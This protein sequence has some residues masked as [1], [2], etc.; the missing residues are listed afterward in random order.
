[1]NFKVHDDGLLILD[2]DRDERGLTWYIL[3]LSSFMENGKIYHVVTAHFT[4]TKIII[5]FSYS[6]CNGF[7]SSIKG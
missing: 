7:R 6:N 3:N 4:G 1:M 2:R 5:N